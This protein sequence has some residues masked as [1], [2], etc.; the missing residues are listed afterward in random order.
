MEFASVSSEKITTFIDRHIG[1]RI[2][3]LIKEAKAKR[4]LP[5]EVA[6]PLALH[7]FEQVQ[8]NANHPSLLGRLFKV[9]LEF[10]RRGWIPCSLVSPLSLRYFERTL[11]TPA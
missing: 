5:R 9:G 3:W 2:A 11:A 4:V 1:T 7:R 10:Y 8:Q 6:V